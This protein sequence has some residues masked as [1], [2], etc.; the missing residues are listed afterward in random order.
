M[1]KKTQP[2]EFSTLPKWLHWGSLVMLLGLMAAS[3]FMVE[4]EDG[5]P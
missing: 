1:K 5:D 2:F 4:L 3:T